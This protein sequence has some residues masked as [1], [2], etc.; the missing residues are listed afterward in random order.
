M[1]SL[2]LKSSHFYTGLKQTADFIVFLTRRLSRDHCA[3]TS[4]SLTYTSLLAI[5]PSMVVGFAIIREFPV[6]PEVINSLQAAI[7]K[8]FTPDVGEGVTHYI[9]HLVNKGKRL[10][11]LSFSVLI[12]SA[13]MT[14]YT[15]DDTLNRIWHVEFRRRTWFSLLLY[16]LVIL[17]GPILVG[18]SLALT[19]YL[20]SRPLGID[21]T[22][23]VRWLASVPWLVTFIAFTAVYR[24]VPN[25]RVRW[26]YAVS[27]GLVAMLLF[28]LAKWGFALYIRW[29]PTYGLLYGALAGIPLTLVWIYISWLVVLVGAE[30]ARCL[31]V[32]PD[33]SHRPEL[34]A[35]QLLGYFLV[36]RESGL[37]IDQVTAWGYWGRRRLKRILQQLQAADLV[38]QLDTGRYDL[39]DKSLAMDINALISELTRQ[40]K[41]IEK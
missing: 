23:G 24:W 3:R 16:L 7:L 26:K 30:T 2:S 32:Y 39:S 33:E 5:V 17:S 12:F 35:R 27:G 29:V 36:S 8:I 10:P 28:E 22:S 19:T 21:S 11:V 1:S 18:T 40:M 34:T 20:L 6:F 14:L 38:R 31:A 9:Q 25:T 4:A 13:V 41:L 15:V 37:T